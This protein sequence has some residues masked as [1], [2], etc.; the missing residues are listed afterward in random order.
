MKKSNIFIIL[1]TALLCGGCGIIGVLGTPGR[2]ER[3][4]TAEYNLA[5]RPENKILVIVNQQGWLNAEAN[6]R[7]YLTKATNKYLAEKV[8]IPTENLVTYSELSEFRSGRVDFSFLSP[9]EV[10]K[11]L[12]TDIVLLIMIEEFKLQPIAQTDYYK[13]DLNA[14]A[15][16]FD[17]ATTEK[18]WPET[19]N[20]KS[21]K[22]GFDV[23][24]NGRE[25][26]VNRLL[27]AC[28]HCTVRY[29]YDCPKNKFKIADDRS[30]VSWENWKD[31]TGELE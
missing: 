4:I 14:Q 24:Q 26:A 12:N 11:A 15:V 17:T 10:G 23:E 1:S 7:Y 25:I 28:A 13:G 29:F 22:V 31:S 27:A 9:A 5:E 16:L 2:G 6:L 30:G 21:I 20:G 18:L 19:A 8:K 3:K